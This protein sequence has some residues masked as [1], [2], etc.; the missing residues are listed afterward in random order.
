[1]SS[2]DKV[3]VRIA[4]SPTGKLHIGTARTALFNY[5]FAKK[6][7]GK[8]ILRF[9][10]TDVSRSTK[11]YEK[12]ITDSLRWLELSW[13]EGPY[14]QMER[15]SRYKEIANSL[16]SK[17]LAYGKEGA[18][19]LN[20]KAIIDKFKV[21]YKKAKVLAKERGNS[22]KGVGYTIE[23][24]KKD[25]ILGKISG[26][27][28]DFVLMRA[29]GMP[30]YH[31]A[32]VVDDYDMKISHVIRG[33]DHFPNT[34]KHYLLQKALGYKTPEYAHIPLTL[35]PDKTKL[36]KRF[37]AVA[38]S[39]YK[40]MGYL[41]E[42]LINFMVL[43]GWNPKTEREFFS[44]KELVKE[45][46]FEGMGKS[47]A[48]F[49]VDKLNYFNAY[50]IQGKENKELLEMIRK[51][52]EL[53]IDL[54]RINDDY[55]VKI[56]KVEKLR[57]TSL[58]QIKTFDFYFKEPKYDP[59][60]LIKNST[61]KETLEGLKRSIEAFNQIPKSSWTVEEM[62]LCFGSRILP[63]SGLESWDVYWPV[64]VALSGRE[65]SPS[66]AELLWVFGK[67]ESIKRIKRALEYLK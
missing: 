51:N 65:A 39:D 66:P 35:N 11:E 38:I 30:T 52:K 27:V 15:L 63:N 50:Y 59:K 24:S 10:D 21:K 6:N 16:R 3:K 23:L 44:L 48:V 57:I 22:K 43:L 26:L 36:S 40:K 67:E 55:L 47:S 45:F 56:I 53:N 60:I 31:F 64:R 29:T 58:S 33:Q 41:S 62:I 13:D 25:L 49:D 17:G 14:H 54:D 42:A 12:E 18:L 37:G 34:P 9:E 8:F 46:S 2:K 1:M 19:W 32:V 20:V 5:L 7:K 61:K 4:P 28:S